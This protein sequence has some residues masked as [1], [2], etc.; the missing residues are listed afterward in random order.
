M[1]RSDDVADSIIHLFTLSF[2]FHYAVTL[3]DFE[4]GYFDAAPTSDQVTFIIR[5]SSRIALGGG[6]GGGGGVAEL[7]GCSPSMFLRLIID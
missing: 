2:T 7:C 4:C 5:A 3:R 1:R 6:G